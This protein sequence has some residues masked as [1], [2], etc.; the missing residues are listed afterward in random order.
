VKTTMA[1]LILKKLA[2]FTESFPDI[3]KSDNWLK[4]IIFADFRQ[5][6]TGFFGE[7]VEIRGGDVIT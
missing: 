6:L 3:R 2:G 4:Y 1:L 7:V 5:N